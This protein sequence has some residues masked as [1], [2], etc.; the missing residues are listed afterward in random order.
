MVQERI[1]PTVKSGAIIKNS[2]Y[3]QEIA[4]PQTADKPMAPLK[5]TICCYKDSYIYSYMGLWYFL[6]ICIIVA[7]ASSSQK[8]KLINMCSLT[9]LLIFHLKHDGDMK[10]NPDKTVN[11]LMSDTILDKHGSKVL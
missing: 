10:P 8:N 11:V 9:L 3:G 7:A 6:I 1:K 2:D 5:L 4:Q